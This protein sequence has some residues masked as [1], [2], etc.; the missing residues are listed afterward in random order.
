M[1]P[2]AGYRLEDSQVFS[3]KLFAS[4]YLSYLPVHNTNTPNGGLDQQA[5]LDDQ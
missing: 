2:V 4:L 1:L 5:Y 3:P